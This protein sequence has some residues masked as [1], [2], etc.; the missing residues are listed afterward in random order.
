[1]A[2]SLLLKIAMIQRQRRRRR[3]RVLYILI[4]LLPKAAAAA[5]VVREG[6][7][8]TLPRLPVHSLLT[9]EREPAK[10][11]VVGGSGGGGS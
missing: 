10:P 3:G 9:F 1:M 5:A 7:E 2:R 6:E 11:R 8:A 4:D